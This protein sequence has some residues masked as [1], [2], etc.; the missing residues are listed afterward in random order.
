MF[1]LQDLRTLGCLLCIGALS[2]CLTQSKLSR[3]HC[4]SINWH[5]QGY[6]YGVAGKTEFELSRLASVC[7]SVGSTVD[8]AAYQKGFHSAVIAGCQSPA[9]GFQMGGRGEPL[10][11]QC[12]KEHTPAFYAAWDSGLRTYCV[13]EF[14]F[15]LGRSGGKY[16]PIC[17]E[18]LSPAFQAAF[19]KGHLVFEQIQN[20][21]QQT[22]GLRSRLSQMERALDRNTDLAA[23]LE[24][25]DPN[26]AEL[27]RIRHEV[28]MLKN[29][30]QLL[31][32]QLMHMQSEITRS[33]VHK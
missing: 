24:K 11:K 27:A 6:Q 21:R 14:G 17:P 25:R 8:T 13:P 2:G 15:E 5:D 12:T 28:L 26:S 32:N 10:P 3:E 20:L 29:Q 18:S 22:K 30:K 7:Q 19:Q 23:T 1:Y 31:E 4:A 9:K 33:E 16:N